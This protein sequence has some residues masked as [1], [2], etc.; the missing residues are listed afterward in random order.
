MWRFLRNRL[1]ILHLHTIFR[2]LIYRAHRAVVPAIAWHLVIIIVIVIII[3]RY[4]GIYIVRWCQLKCPLNHAKRSFHRSLNFVFDKLGRI[5]SEEV[6]LHLVHCKCLPILIHVYALE[7]CP[8]TKTDHR[9]LDFV[10]VR[11]LMKLF[12]TPNSDIVNECRVYF[13]FKLPSEIIPTRT[14]KFMSK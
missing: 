5:A 7:V 10:V 2:S 4:L 12:C 3:I 9:S 8:L 11:F 1:L 13:G 14:D 6:V